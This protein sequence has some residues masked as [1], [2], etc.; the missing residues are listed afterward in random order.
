MVILDLEFFEESILF[1]LSNVI[2]VLLLI[3]I[4]FEFFI[5]VKGVYVV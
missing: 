5:A 1:I 4:L 2:T 3:E